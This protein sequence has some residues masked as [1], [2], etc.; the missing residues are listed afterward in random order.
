MNEIAV[1]SP[2]EMAGLSS[3]EAVSRR[4]E[5][6]PN[7]VAEE[8]VHPLKRLARHFWAPVPWMLEATIA[9]QI[10]IGQRLTALLIAMLLVLNVILGAFQESQVVPGSCPSR[11]EAAAPAAHRAA[12]LPSPK[13]PN[14]P[15][16]ASASSTAA[17]SWLRAA[18]SSRSR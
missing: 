18:K 14:A 12:R 15:A 16:V 17:G 2:S 6:G 7:V 8:Q 13:Q 5:Y 10:V 9:L 4:A 3:A 1:N 11:S